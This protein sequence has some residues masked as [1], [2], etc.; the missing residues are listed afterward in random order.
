M[1]YIVFGV[2]VIGAIIAT[3]RD[4][5]NPLAWSLWLWACIALLYALRP[6][7]LVELNG[8]ATIVLCVGIIGLTIPSLLKRKRTAAAVLQGERSVAFARLFIISVIAVALL[9]IGA[10]AFRNGVS[11]AVG[12][13][14]GNLSLSDVRAAQTGTAR[15]GGFLALLVAV[16]PLVS[17]LGIYGAYRYHP[18][19]LVLTITAVAATLQNPA[20]INMLTLGAVTVV[21]WLYA[22]ESLSTTDQPRGHRRLPFITIIGAL[23]VALAYFLAVG[24]QLA[25]NDSATAYAN[26]L[27]TWLVSPVS[28]FLGGPSAFTVATN[29]GITPMDFG[30]SIYLPLRI[31]SAI[32][33]G[34]QTPDTIASPVPAPMWFNVYTGFG[35]MYFDF[36]FIGVF[37]LSALLGTVAVLAHRQALR[38]KMEWAWI[39]ACVA[40]LL[41]S[42]PQAFRL[43]NLDVWFQFAIGFWAFWVIRR[44]HRHTA[45]TSV[46]RNAEKRP[47]L[48]R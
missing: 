11:E 26:W 22:R 5:R 30:T 42:L 21:F 48:V 31:A 15:G 43:F 23:A 27:P 37:V 4:R 19:W 35:Q 25:K 1:G 24:N 13:S 46:L 38:G 20:R 18:L 14:Y 2:A 10:W 34:I 44:S 29:N 8:T 12:A 9:L 3:S 6:L 33:P 41:F 28:Y 17:C 45:P 32:F 16:G 40:A 7:D 39:A 36:G 47:T